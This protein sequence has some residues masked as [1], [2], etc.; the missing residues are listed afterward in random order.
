MIRWGVQSFQ[1]DSGKRCDCSTSKGASWGVWVWYLL[2][3]SWLR[4]YEQGGGSGEEVPG[5]PHNM[6]ER[7]PLG[8]PGNILVY[9]RMSWW[10]W[11]GRWRS[12]PLCLGC[13]HQ[14]FLNRVCHF[15]LNGSSVIKL[16]CCKQDWV[17]HFIIQIWYHF[18]LRF[19]WK[20]VCHGT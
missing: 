2:A 6:L 3:A 19:S 14:Y 9:S 5:K 11:L 17:K 18:L 1:G 16:K 12:E 15:E 4:C 13:G 7:L 10:R 8:W 20:T